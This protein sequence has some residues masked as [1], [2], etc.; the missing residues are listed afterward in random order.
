[1]RVTMAQLAERAG[2]SVSTVS[3]AFSGKRKLSAQTR[4]RILDV[5]QELNYPIPSSIYANRVRSRIVAVS[6]PIHSYSTMR[7]YSAFFFETLSSLRKYGCDLLLCANETDEIERIARES[8]VDGVVLLD[9]MVSDERARTAE[10]LSLPTV[11]IGIPL[12][13]EDTFSRIFSIDVDFKAVA[14]MT[15]QR[16]VE[17][18]RT[19]LLYVGASER[20]Y[21]AGSNYL[22]MYRKWLHRY[23]LRNLISVKTI[24]MPDDSSQYTEFF[25]QILRDNPEIDAVIIQADGDIAPAIYP[26]ISS[27]VSSGKLAA[28]AIGSFGKLDTDRARLDEIPLEPRYA[29]KRAVEVLENFVNGGVDEMGRVEYITPRYLDRGTFQ[30]QQG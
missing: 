30:E 15:V 3:Y 16:A 17:K 21:N 23:A 28:L 20:A 22:N 8:V 29:C 27:A 7:G 24:Y 4:K 25:Q 19:R 11:S 1:M 12:G 18:G 9:V 26:L 5:A 2:V 6:A 13:P 10:N 14:R